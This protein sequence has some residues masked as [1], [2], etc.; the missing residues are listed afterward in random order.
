MILFVIVIAII[1]L[2]WIL[3]EKTYEAEV[4][5]FMLGM[6]VGPFFLIIL[7]VIS[8]GNHAFP[9]KQITNNNIRY[10]S[11]IKRQSL[12]NSDYENYTKSDT[13][14]DIAEWNIWVN[15]EKNYLDSPWTNVLVSKRVIDNL[16]Y[17]DE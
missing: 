7:T 6:V 16:K 17:I 4:I 3:Y 15:T 13:I 12:F 1:V 9:E 11:L 2:G 5:G 14:R 10:E 8:I